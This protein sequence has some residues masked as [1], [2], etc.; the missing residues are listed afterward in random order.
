[1]K[2]TELFA[3][4]KAWLEYG[5]S[6]VFS[7]IQP[8][9]G[10]LRRADVLGLHGDIVTVVELKKSLNLDV[11]GQCVEWE[12]HAHLIYAAV[13][14]PIQ[15]KRMKLSHGKHIH[16]FAERIMRQYGIGLLYVGE[17]GQVEIVLR[18]RLNRRITS[19]LPE[20]INEYHESL[21]PEGGTSGGG[22][23]TTYRTTMLRLRE[24]LLR[25]HDRYDSVRLKYSKEIQD[26]WTPMNVI[27]DQ[28]TTHY[29]SPKSSLGTA[30]LKFEK[31]WC[32][33]TIINR[34]RYYRVRPELVNH[35]DS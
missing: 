16:K 33:S 26:G 7:E 31:D 25:M 35:P 3:P 9:K 17:M 23:I 32:E 1:M 24:F 20:S 22:Y 34:R 15:H 2:E 19:L 27:L 11:M 8:H 12:P 4:V 21:S 28:C 5:G 29:S 10:T 18:P 13:P 14:E 6:I 30:L